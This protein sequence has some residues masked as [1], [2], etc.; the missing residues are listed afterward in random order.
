MPT[1]KMNGKRLPFA[2]KDELLAY[3]NR[4]REAG[5]ANALEALL[6]SIPGNQEGCLIAR[7][8]N[9]GC[10]VYPLTSLK[11]LKDGSWEW[12][13]ETPNDDTARK[14][15]KGIGARTL[16]LDYW[17]DVRAAKHEIETRLVVLL[18]KRIGNAAHAFD[19]HHREF[20]GLRS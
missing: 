18:P 10:K 16:R 17:Q 20:D 4:I 8:L 3:A 14:L 1:L 12:V 2:G 19:E 15:A 11:N 13:M 6:P 9:F 5:G 7:A